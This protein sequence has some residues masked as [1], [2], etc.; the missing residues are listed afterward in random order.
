MSFG[1]DMGP[2]IGT[3]I[4]KIVCATN[5]RKLNSTSHTLFKKAQ[6][7]SDCMDAAE[8]AYTDNVMPNDAEG[9]RQLLSLLHD[10]KR[11]VLE[12]SMHTLQEAQTLLGRLRNMTTEGATLDSRPLQI[13]TNI[14]FGEYRS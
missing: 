10:H 5:G 2:N 6:Q 11:A 7:Y 4:N 8:R 14:D 12:A 3:T 1:G 9:A 13:R